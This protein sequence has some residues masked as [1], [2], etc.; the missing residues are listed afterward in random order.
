MS[1]APIGV[2]PMKIAMYRAT[3]R[4]RSCGAVDSWTVAL[5]AVIR[6]SDDSPTG[7]SATAKVR[8]VGASAATTLNTPKAAVAPRTRLVRGFSR[9][10]ASSA[11]PSEPIAITEPSSPYSPD[12]WW[13]T[14]LAI[15]AVVSWKLS[16]NVPTSPTTV[17]SRIRSGRPRT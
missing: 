8:Y 9:R 7:I 17:S 1:G 12:P 11:P 15:S 6:V 4:P 2:P 13:N 16:P 3:T 14:V 5:A 10:A